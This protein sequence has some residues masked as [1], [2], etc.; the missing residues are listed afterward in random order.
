MGEQDDGNRW[1]RSRSVSG[2]DY[3][4]TYERRAAAGEDVHGEASFVESLGPRSVLDAGCGTGRVARELARRGL[5]V[6]GVDIDPEML[7]T[8][9]AKAPDLDWR[10]G[11][12]ACFDL[13]RTFD[14]VVMAGNVIIFVTPATEGAVLAN[15]ARHLTPGGL[16]VAGFQLIPGRLSLQQ[17][18]RLAAEAGLALAERWSTWDRAPW[19]PDA[20]YAVSVHRGATERQQ[21]VAASARGSRGLP[22]SPGSIPA[23]ATMAEPRFKVYISADGDFLRTEAGAIRLFASKENAESTA[24]EQGGFVL[25][26]NAPPPGGFDRTWA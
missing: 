21:P 3:D 16:L 20:G 2:H 24:Q 12:I 23:G 14:C 6:A 9:R 5:D 4:G 18:D 8:A 19:Q 1:L 17:Y 7:G 10:L 15:M 25:P 11:D 22:K 13:G 26:E